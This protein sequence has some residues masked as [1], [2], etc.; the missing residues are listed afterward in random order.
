LDT[1]ASVT[2]RS[3]YPVAAQEAASVQALLVTCRRIAGSRAGLDCVGMC[4]RRISA[5]LHAPAERKWSCDIEDEAKETAMSPAER[6]AAIET[7]HEAAATAYVALQAKA[8]TQ[9]EAIT[10]ALEA[11]QDGI[12]P[13]RQLEPRR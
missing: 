3:G 11:H 6:S 9:I 2:H 10:A 5:G 8:A 7:Q 13:A 12:D 4:R 1:A